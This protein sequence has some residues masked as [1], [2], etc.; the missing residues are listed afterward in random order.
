MRLLRE[1]SERGTN[2]NSYVHSLVLVGRRFPMTSW[3][4]GADA[5][6][7][8]NC[9]EL[10]VCRV[11]QMQ[12]YANERLMSTKSIHDP[13]LADLPGGLGSHFTC[14]ALHELGMACDTT[15]WWIIAS[16]EV[17]HTW[18]LHAGVLP[19]K[20]PGHLLFVWCA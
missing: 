19:G 13:V 1:T 15:P 14:D 5:I 8:N 12:E 6:F 10:V 11:Y 17:Y 9:F 18:A 16:V 3:D 2:L 4:N 20:P 7:S